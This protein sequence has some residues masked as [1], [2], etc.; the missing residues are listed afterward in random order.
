MPDVI[1][2]RVVADHAWLVTAAVSREDA[3][4]LAA[5]TQPA[6]L[7]ALFDRALRRFHD[8]VL[9]DGSID[10][11]LESTRMQLLQPLD[12]QERSDRRRA[13]RMDSATSGP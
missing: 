13:L 2:H 5:K 12:E 1:E 3:S 7:V 10:N 11:W 9:S 8:E 6:D 4:R